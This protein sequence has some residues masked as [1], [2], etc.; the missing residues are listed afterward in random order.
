MLKI[1]D[2]KLKLKFRPGLKV[3]CIRNGKD[4]WISRYQT[5]CAD[6]QADN[7]KRNM[8]EYEIIKESGGIITN[9]DFKKFKK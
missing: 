2:R 9:K 5:K 1:P 8:K 3:C 7:F 4:I 6:C